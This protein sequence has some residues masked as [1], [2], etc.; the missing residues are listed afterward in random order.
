MAWNTWTCTHG[1][2]VQGIWSGVDYTDVNTCDRSH[3]G[4]I[5]ATGDDFGNVKLF[6]Y[7]CTVPKA[8]FNS[9]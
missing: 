4:S 7:P 9:Y 2:P 3:D 1:F 5:I 8:E 6:K